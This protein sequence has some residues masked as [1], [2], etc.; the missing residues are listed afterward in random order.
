MKGISDFQKNP[1]RYHSVFTI[2]NV[3]GLTLLELLAGV[4]I[5]AVLIGLLL[6][7]IEKS[8]VG[9]RTVGCSS[10]M[11]QLAA[12]LLAYRA[13]H[14]GWF[15]PGYQIFAHSQDPDGESGVRVQGTYS[16]AIRSGLFGSSKN[17]E[18]GYLTEMPT[19][20]AQRL[21]PAGKEKHGNEKKYRQSQG[22]Y[23]INGYLLGVKPEAL[24]GSV[25]EHFKKTY[26]GDSRMLLLTE[27]GM[28]NAVWA[29]DSHVSDLL[30]KEPVYNKETLP[31]DHGNLRLNFLFLDGH[32]E[33]LAPKETLPDKFDWSEHF[34]NWGENGRNILPSRLD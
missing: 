11:R 29:I 26:P 28:L 32:M 9:A 14:N 34:N 17:K 31:R 18:D 1:R 33:L 4:V 8:V 21:T 2:P 23:A 15:P 12:A 22:S 3:T 6:P 19:C 13:E 5:L 25:W 7:A 10:S 16:G 24:P 27:R 30:R 20:P